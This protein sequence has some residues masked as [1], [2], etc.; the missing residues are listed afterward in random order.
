M[1]MT[2]MG[3]VTEVWREHAHFQSRPHR[4]R[5]VPRQLVG[6]FYGYWDAVRYVDELI[7]EHRMCQRNGWAY[8]HYHYSHRMIQTYTRRPIRAYYDDPDLH[9]T[10]QEG[11]I[12]I[13]D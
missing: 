7:E 4:N 5:R 9:T 12:I 8:R 13:L 3:T 10:A 1:E 6:I 11:E 2:D